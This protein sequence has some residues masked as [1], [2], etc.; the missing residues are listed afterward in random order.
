MKAFTFINGMLTGILIGVLIAPAS[1]RE[2]RRNLFAKFSNLKDSVS[3]ANENIKEEV[4]AE[5]DDLKNQEEKEIEKTL[6]NEK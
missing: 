3:R 1:G 6:R 2:T 4:S 5:L